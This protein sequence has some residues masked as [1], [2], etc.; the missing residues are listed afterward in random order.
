MKWK[1]IDDILKKLFIKVWFQILLKNLLGMIFISSILTGVFIIISHFKVVVY[2]EKKI[3]YIWSILFFISLIKTILNKPSNKQI[4]MEGDKLGLQ[5]KLLT[6][7]ELDN[8]KHNDTFEIFKNDLE[9]ELQDFDLIKKYSIKFNNKYALASLFIIIASLGINFIPSTVKEQTSEIEVIN[10]NIRNIAKDTKKAEKKMV[11]GIKDGKDKK[12]AEKILKQLE[13]KLNKTYDYN[14]A[15]EEICKTEEQ[16]KN[17]KATNNRQNEKLLSSLLK[18]TTL[19]GSKLDFQLSTGNVN[20]KDLNS[21]NAQ[22]STQDVKKISDNLSKNKD[23]KYNKDFKNKVEKVLSKPKVTSKELVKSIENK[24]Q[25]IKFTNEFNKSKDKLVAKKAEKDFESSSGNKKSDNFTLGK[26]QSS[27]KYGDK[28]KKK[29]SDEKISGNGDTKNEDNNSVGSSKT[30]FNKEV[31]EKANNGT[32][33]KESGNK[34]S[35]KSENVLN[36]NSRTNNKGNMF[37]KSVEEVKG[38]QGKSEYMKGS[39]FNYRKEYM[40]YMEKYNIPMD[41]ENMIIEYFDK[42]NNRRN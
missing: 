37:N 13:K 35:Y 42:I 20:N 26:K 24:N 8:K 17:L 11:E 18:G 2:L 33:K 22:L 23:I 6:Y 15:Y 34:A 40:D 32:I 38:Q 25:D 30:G 31:K 29:S 36:V 39:S 5:E 7:V 3:L 19:E 10:K 16:I 14:K 41:K 27:Y 9:D 12:E 1:T 21:E 4:A 28:S